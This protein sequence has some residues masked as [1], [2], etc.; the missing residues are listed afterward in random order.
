MKTIQLMA[1]LW[2]P[3][4]VMAT[5]QTDN[6]SFQGEVIINYIYANG[7]EHVPIRNDTGNTQVYLPS[8]GAMVPCELS[9]LPPQD[10]DEGR[11]KNYSNGDLYINGH[12]GFDFTKFTQDG[13]ALPGSEPVGSTIWKCTRDN[14]TGLYW[15]VK[16]NDN[17]I[18][19]VD[20]LY[21]WGGLTHVGSNYGLYNNDWDALVVA[22]NNENLC[23]F[24][25][26]R[27]PTKEELSDILDYGAARIWAQYY[28][29][30][31]FIYF[32]STNLRFWTATPSAVA[33]D[34]AWYVNF[35]TGE[36]DNQSRNANFAIVL[37]RGEQ[38]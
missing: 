36:F 1:F 23:G 18:H 8:N 32:N 31:T 25:D 6:Q 16:T 9:T 37:V 24:S 7:F 17:S 28:Q 38:P 35:K 26:W 10:C 33:D 22:T 20:N 12:A 2:L 30:P 29:T 3:L 19:D 34:L 11:D 14:V 5:N 21:Q 15:E 4:Q 27:V 13:I